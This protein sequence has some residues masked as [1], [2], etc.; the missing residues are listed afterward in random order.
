MQVRQP[1][2]FG[3]QK[4]WRL[5]RLLTIFDKPVACPYCQSHEG[6]G[7]KGLHQGIWKNAGVLASTLT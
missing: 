4:G 7:E 3:R 1:D 5:S 2:V 6:G